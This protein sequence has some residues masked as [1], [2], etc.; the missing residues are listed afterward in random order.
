MSLFKKKNKSTDG[1]V[2]ID[3]NELVEKRRSPVG[4]PLL[5]L[6]I[7]GFVMT[8][9]QMY[10][11]G[12]KTIDVM[13]FRALHMAFGMCILFLIYP[14]TK[15]SS[16]TKIPWYDWI[17][18]ALATAPNLYIAIFFKQLAQRAGTVNTVDLIMG[19]IMII[20]ILEGARRVV[21]LLLTCIAGFFLLYTLFGQYFPGA[22]AH[23]GASLG[24]LVRH[25]AFTTEG[26]F[27]VALGASASFIFLFCLLGALMNA[28]GSDKV[29]IDLAVAVFG[30]QRGGPAKAAVVSSALFGTISGSSLAN[31]TTT[32]TFTIPLMK[33]VGYK[34]EFAGAVEAT[35]SCGGQIMPPVMGAAAFIIA[36]FL[37]KSYL[38]V[39]LAAAVPALLY[40]TG[41]FAAVHVTACKQGLKGIPADQLPSA[42][43]VLKEQGYLLLPLLAIIVVLV[44]GM[45][46]QMSAFVGVILT[47]AIS[48]VKKES[49]FTA[50]KLFHAFADGAKGAVDVMI[51][52]AV[53][54][55]IV[56]SFTLSGLGVKMA[57]LVTALAH[58]NLF[59]TL[60]FSAL[61][62]IILG[63]G[64]PT[65]AN[66]IMMS[67]ITVPAVTMMGVHPLAAHLFCFYFGIVSDLTPPVALAALC[68]AGIAKAKFWPTAFN[69]TR[70][71]IAAYIIP[72]FFVYNPVLLLGQLPFAFGTVQ[73]VVMAV[74]GIIA[75][76]CGLF[77]YIVD[78][79]S[80][81][82]RIIII[83]AGVAMVHPGT[84]TDVIGVV[85]IAA[86]I[87]LQFIRKKKRVAAAA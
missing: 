77:G 47:I 41:I 10:C 87:V 12:F 6:N 79:A 56:G 75:I 13:Q 27:G 25:M 32:G 21:G 26:V 46:P 55:F 2:D 40:F 39:C 33:G 49:R 42:K 74:I 11:A 76:S 60:L 57:S 66:Y 7:I 15:K 35:A 37:G 70:I 38:E 29:M 67:M 53:V 34:G 58:N 52:C 24:G 51:A 62:S 85:V 80:M 4:I 69:A 63:M 68:G 71:G 50:K 65:T 20:M 59:L 78:E 8:L 36:E 86:M 1:V 30:K 44:C 9:F 54:G 23:R 5:I 81:I 48:Y 16:R 18:A 14:M 22:L 83:A 19:I 82:E 84:I 17:F 61:A 31:V 64:V 73:A 43:K 3:V 72:F 45:S 28:L